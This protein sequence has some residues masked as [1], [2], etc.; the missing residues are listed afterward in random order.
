MEKDKKK[1]WHF[2]TVRSFFP[3]SGGHR[4]KSGTAIVSSGHWSVYNRPTEL[5]QRFSCSGFKF[6]KVA[7]FRGKSGK[8]GKS[9]GVLYHVSKFLN[10]SSKSP[11]K[12]RKCYLK[13]APKYFIGLEIIWA[14][15]MFDDPCQNNHLAWSVKIALQSKVR[16]I[17]CSGGFQPYFV[18]SWFCWITAD[19]RHADSGKRLPSSMLFCI[20][21][22]S[23]DTP[24]SFRS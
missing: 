12:V 17:F 18:Q 1:F 2:H 5:E 11:W 9:Q 21:F 24:G 7:T 13:V 22:S 10:P 3:N 19:P 15:L 8:I 6:C 23:A 4:C 14:I 16:D 20:F